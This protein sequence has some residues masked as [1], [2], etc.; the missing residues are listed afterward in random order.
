MKCLNQDLWSEWL[1]RK[2]FPHLSIRDSGNA[3]ILSGTNML[4]RNFGA[5]SAPHG[6]LGKCFDF[7]SWG[8]WVSRAKVSKLSSKK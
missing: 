1:V 3:W 4:W 8:L 5:P 6:N 7:N 2:P